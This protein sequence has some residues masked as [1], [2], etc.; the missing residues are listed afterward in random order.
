MIFLFVGVLTFSIL[1]L[2]IFRGERRCGLMKEKITTKLYLLVLITF[3]SFLLVG[4]S[5]NGQKT[6]EVKNDEGEISNM[7]DSTTVEDSVY[8]M[9]VIDL[10]S[11]ITYDYSNPNYGLI[12][13]DAKSS[14]IYNFD[15]IKIYNLI[16]VFNSIPL[17]NKIKRNLASNELSKKIIEGINIEVSYKFTTSTYSNDDALVHFYILED[18]TLCFED[19]RELM[20][21]YSEPNFIDFQV[22]KQKIIDVGGNS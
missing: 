19:N 20:L 7:N 2:V 10:T 5:N 17:N 14:Y 9:D 22:F 16:S 6:H 1:H 11:S 15:G 21:F 4:C 18:G 8:Y 3:F 12:T 13:L